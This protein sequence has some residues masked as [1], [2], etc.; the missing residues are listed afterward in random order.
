MEKDKIN[1]VHKWQMRNVFKILVRKPEG[2]SHLGDQMVLTGTG[3]E[4]VDWI[5]LTEDRVQSG[6]SCDYGN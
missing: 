4:C 2:K 6:G 3:C 1:K 5:P